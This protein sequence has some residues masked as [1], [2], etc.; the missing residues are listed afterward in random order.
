MSLLEEEGLGLAACPDALVSQALLAQLQLLQTLVPTLGWL[1]ACP[2]NGIR[3]L[4]SCGNLGNHAPG[5]LEELVAL[6]PPVLCNTPGLPYQ[7]YPVSTTQQN[8]LGTDGQ[9][10][11]WVVFPLPDPQKDCHGYL[12]A[13]EP[14]NSTAEQPG[15]YLHAQKC[16]AALSAV[17]SLYRQL[18]S[19][20]QVMKRVEHRAVTDSLTG[21]F[22]RA[23]WM[24]HLAR[25]DDQ[26]GKPGHDLGILV[27]DLDYLKQVNDTRGHAAGDDLLCRTAKVIL[28]V[29]R[30]QDPVGR[31]GGDEFGVLVGD[32]TRTGLNALV[33]RIAHAMGQAGIN[34]SMGMA[35]RSE[36]RSLKQVM[37]L[38][39]QRMY[40]N[41]FTK[42]VPPGAGIA[43][44]SRLF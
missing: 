8:M 18:G 5:F 26:A 17:L 21:V 43:R 23:G 40:E 20:Q 36:A 37:Q 42:P 30:Q 35:L 11:H 38:A 7:R 27:L 24:A 32:A 2:E 19:V 10:C 44:R 3:V 4:A 6:Q 12:L 13:L 41:K 22:N 25:L 29:V 28:S 34:I 39:D 1:V 16:A 15:L 9:H 14:Q 33:A 31:L